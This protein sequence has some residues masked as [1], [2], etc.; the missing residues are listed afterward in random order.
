MVCKLLVLGIP[1]NA[2][3]GT[4]ITMYE[5]LYDIDCSDVLLAK[6][7]RECR[8]VIRIVCETLTA[9][10]LASTDDWKQ[11][12][13][14]ETSRCQQSFSTLIIGIAGEEGELDPVIV[15]SCMF[16]PDG[17]ADSTFE[18]IKDNIESLKNIAWSACARC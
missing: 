11:I 18:A 9:M 14:D 4:I 16:V 3:P 7:A 8:D 10:K 6:F 2:I 1:P 15:S 12:F 17:S 5:S 13:T